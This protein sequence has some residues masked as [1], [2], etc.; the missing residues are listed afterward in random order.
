MK[1]CKN[2]NSVVK[3]LTKDSKTWDKLSKSAKKEEKDDKE[4]IKKLKKK[5]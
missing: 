3:H 1:K 2:K 5:K 4:L